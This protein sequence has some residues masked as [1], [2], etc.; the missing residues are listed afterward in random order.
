MNE[1][2]EKPFEVACDLDADD[3]LPD[4]ES[5]KSE[6]ASEDDDSHD[7]LEQA[8]VK[9]EDPKRWTDYSSY[10]AELDYSSLDETVESTWDR[11]SL[12][13]VASWAVAEAAF[14]ASGTEVGNWILVNSIA[15]SRS[16]RSTIVFCRL[17]HRF[18]CMKPDR[19]WGLDE[20][21]SE[22][23]VC[24]PPKTPI[25]LASPQICWIDC[26]ILCELCAGSWTVPKFQF[27]SS[28]SKTFWTISSQF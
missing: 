21:G 2:L 3:D 10:Q 7:H 15:R 16:F 19:P 25:A 12:E 26:Q 22:P 23:R 28:F 11:P 24:R 27:S 9:E 13:F 1:I 18:E 6:E 17:R 8:F 5:E 14:D 4:V 20:T